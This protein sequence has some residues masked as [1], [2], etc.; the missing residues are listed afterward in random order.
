MC[1]ISYDYLSSLKHKIKCFKKLYKSFFSTQWIWFKTSKRTQ[2]R[3]NIIKVVHMIS[4]PFQIFWSHAIK[5]DHY[6]EKL[7]LYGFVSFLRLESL[8]AGIHKIIC[9][10]FVKTWVSNHSLVL[11]NHR[12]QISQKI[13]VHNEHRLWFLFL[14]ADND[15]IQSVDF[16]HILSKYFD[17]LEKI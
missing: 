16:K 9:V 7:H 3:H 8:K 1:S 14:A 13:A 12:W 6:Y 5:Y 10:M 11:V 4:D 2:K 17:I 15:S